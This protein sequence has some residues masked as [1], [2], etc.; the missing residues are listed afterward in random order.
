MRLAGGTNWSKKNAY[1]MVVGK[2]ERKRPQGRPR[3]RSVD[4]IKM[5]RREIGGGGMDR[6]VLS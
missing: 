4:N 1:I 6:I 2:P 3:Y 5:Y